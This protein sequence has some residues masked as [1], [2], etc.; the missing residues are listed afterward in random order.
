MRADLLLIEDH[1]VLRTV[2]TELGGSTVDQVGRRSQLLDHLL[3]VLDVHVQIEDELFYPAIREVS[4]LFGVA[5][6]EHRQIDDQLAVVFRTDPA[7]E[8]FAIEVAMLT[9]TLEHHATEEETDMFPQARAALGDPALETLG[10]Q[11]R[12]RQQRLRQS[13]VTHTRLQIKRAALRHL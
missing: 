11:M 12:Q 2:L 7:S 10:E 1:T 6:A 3:D 9:A 5:H 8:D 13:P 4:P